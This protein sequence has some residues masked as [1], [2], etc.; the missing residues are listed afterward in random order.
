MVDMD[1]R[2]DVPSLT[3]MYN[4]K[5]LQTHLLIQT[6]SRVNRKYPVKNMV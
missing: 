6:I 5:P 4:D 1:H 2:L 3:Y